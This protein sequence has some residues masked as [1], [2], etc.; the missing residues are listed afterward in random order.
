M[1]EGS[2]VK[3]LSSTTPQALGHQPEGHLPPL[4]PFLRS[5]DSLS[6]VISPKLQ[7]SDNRVC[8]VAATPGPTRNRNRHLY[9]SLLGPAS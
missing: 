2:C 8:H 7:A 5:E 1:G 6:S 4:L 3:G 9:M